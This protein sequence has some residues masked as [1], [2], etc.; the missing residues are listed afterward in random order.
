MGTRKAWFST[1]LPSRCS[2]RELAARALPAA[3]PHRRTAPVARNR[4]FDV[5]HKTSTTRLAGE[6]VHYPMAVWKA[7]MERAA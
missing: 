5:C 1:L 2:W 6:R 7:Q 4:G 3:A